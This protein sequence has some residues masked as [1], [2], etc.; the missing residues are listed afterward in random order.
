MHDKNI[1]DDIM[2]RRSSPDMISI[3]RNSSECDLP[4]L[5]LALSDDAHPPPV[6]FSSR[7]YSTPSP[8]PLLSTSASVDDRGSRHSNVKDSVSHEQN[9]R[10]HKSISIQSTLHEEHYESITNSPCVPVEGKLVDLSDN[11]SYTNHDADAANDDDEEGGIVILDESTE[12]EYEE[13]ICTTSEN[14]IMINSNTRWCNI[15]QQHHNWFP[16]III[17]QN[18][19]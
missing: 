19:A 15:I 9:K 10:L 7:H 16:I 11:E 3:L 6:R 5:P 14:T 13:L 17:I 18:N 1:D 12:E 8:L 4:Q 2:Q